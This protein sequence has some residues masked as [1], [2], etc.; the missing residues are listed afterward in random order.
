[1][2]AV[3]EQTS[4]FKPRLRHVALLGLLALGLYVVLPQLGDFRSSWHLLSRAN[5]GW[6]LAAVGLTATTYLTAAATYCLLAFQPLKYGITVV[7]QLAVMFINRLLPGGIGALGANYVYLRKQRHT[8]AQ[9][10]S[11]VAINN[12]LGFIGHSILLAITFLLYNGHLP[13]MAGRS[14]QSLDT[15][16]KWLVPIAVLAV[17]ALLVVGRRRLKHFLIDLRQQL[18]DYRHRPLRLAGALL[19]SIGLTLGNV[20]CLYFCALAVGLNLPFAAVLLVLTLGVGAGTAV[21]TPGGVGSFEAGLVAGLVAYGVSSS[22]ALAV[23]LLYRLISYWLAL[24]FGSVAFFWAERR[25]LLS[26]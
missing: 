7:V 18:A 17:V 9:A 16:I 24:A 2:G 3:T 10:G 1:M 8:V 13:S 4:R 26:V 21:P 15:I 11:M 14:N 12:L 5:L 25:H 22:Q 6:T 20:L 19:S 23:A